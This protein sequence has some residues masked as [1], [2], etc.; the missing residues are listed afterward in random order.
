[1]S[2]KTKSRDIIEAN[3]ALQ[4]RKV[5][6]IQRAPTVCPDVDNLNTDDVDPFASFLN[7]SYPLKNMVDNV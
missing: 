5:N 2:S 6:R 7:D 3:A 1:M 4:E